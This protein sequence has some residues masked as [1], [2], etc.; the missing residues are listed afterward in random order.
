MGIAIF[1]VNKVDSALRTHTL[2]YTRTTGSDPQSLTGTLVL[3]DST[4]VFESGQT[5]LPNWIN[6]LNMTYTNAS[7]NATNYTKDDFDAVNFVKSVDTVDF[8]AGRDLVSQFSDIKFF[9]F[10]GGPTGGSPNF[11]M[12]IDF[13]E[14]ELTSTPGPTPFLAFLPFIYLINKIKGSIKSE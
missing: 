14:F 4:V 5:P 3:D 7:G 12:G 8:S 10:S 11:V 2:N 1:N 13:A 6:T 9:S